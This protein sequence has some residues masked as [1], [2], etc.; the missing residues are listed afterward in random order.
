MRE[1]LTMVQN[2]TL[3][4]LGTAAKPER[5]PF[6]G[7]EA[8]GLVSFVVELL[9]RFRSPRTVDLRIAGMALQRLIRGID[10][11]PINPGAEPKSEMRRAGR[12]FFGPWHSGR[13]AG[14]LE[15]APDAAYL[16]RRDGTA[17]EPEVL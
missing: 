12:I 5:Q 2:L 1:G 7:A 9:D 16:V 15:G 10:R 14:N 11:N 8:K 3:S 4:M 13:D 6:K 17:W